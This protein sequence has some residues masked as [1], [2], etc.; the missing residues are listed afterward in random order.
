VDVAAIECVHTLRFIAQSEG[1]SFHD[2]TS[3]GDG[4]T[5]SIQGSIC[6]EHCRRCYLTTIALHFDDFMYQVPGTTQSK[7]VPVHCYIAFC[8]RCWYSINNRCTTL[9]LLHVPVPGTLSTW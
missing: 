5:H 3:R 7:R 4:I 6:T 1:I 2:K 8:R 9:L